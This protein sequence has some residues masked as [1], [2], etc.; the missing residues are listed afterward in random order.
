MDEFM[1]SNRE[2]WNEM[3][4]IN[5][6]SEFYDV[7]GFKQ[8]KLSLLPIE[9]E[10]LG[11]VAGKSLL[12]LLCHFGLDTLSWARLG[13]NVTGVDFSD[14][15]IDLARS[16][17]RETGLQSNFICADIYN[18]PKVLD[19]TFDI[20][21]ASYGVLCWLP[22]IEEWARIVSRFLKPG[23]TF[24]IVE[25]HPF[26]NVFDN[27]RG[28]SEL[29]VYYSYFHSAAPDKWE[30]D[31]SYADRE[32][33]LSHPSYEWIYSIGDIINAILSAGLKIEFLHEFPYCCYDHFRFME[34]RADGMWQLPGKET[35]PLTFSLKAIKENSGE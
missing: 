1:K 34:K 24:Y 16:L 2:H 17:S 14:K 3:A 15:A 8:G 11:D 6:K 9:R 4:S 7:E 33:I 20:V 19:E 21:F 30:S 27:Q 12:H 28:I 29:N 35:I 10:E 25:L 13:A 32:A 22:D 31:G 23:G 5:V 18:L 26:I